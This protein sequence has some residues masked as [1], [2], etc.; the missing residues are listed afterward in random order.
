M[1]R[2]PRIEIPGG[3][4]HVHTRGNGRQAIYFGNWS[5]KLFVR[6]LDRTS[7]R[8]GWRILAY[9]LMPN[10]YHLVLQIGESGLSD[11]MCE[12]NGRFSRTSNWVNKRSNHL[13]GSRFTS[14]LIENERYL[15]AACRY[16]L[17][18]PVRKYGND[19]RR[20][21]WSSMR[22]TLG[23]D[24]APACLDADWLVSQFGRN[25]AYARKEFREFVDAGRAIRL[26][27]GTDPDWEALAA[28]RG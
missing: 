24:L 22:A 27:S 3:F 6:E 17:L 19:P 2:A 23:L 16:V 1:G 5:G 14:H 18:N 10:H 20:W 26:V 7:R 21:R 4:Y 15:L 13:F 9:C 25:P 11:G 12:L 8:H 28:D